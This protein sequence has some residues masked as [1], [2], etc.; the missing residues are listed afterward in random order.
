MV[1]QDAVLPPSRGSFCI[2]F[3][4]KFRRGE[5]LGTVTFHRTVVGGKPGHAHYKIFLLQ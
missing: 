2:Q 1:F 3:L 5:S 4:K